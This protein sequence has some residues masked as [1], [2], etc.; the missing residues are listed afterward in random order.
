MARVLVIEDSPL[1]AWLLT[2]QLQSLG[3]MP[4]VEQRCEDALAHWQ[5]GDVDVVLVA[6]QLVRDNGFQCGT[7]LRDAGF[8]RILLLADVPR[9]TDVWWARGLGLGL[10]QSRGL[11]QSQSHG[12]CLAVLQRPL[13]LQ[14]LANALSANAQ[15]AAREQST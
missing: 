11:D 13:T 15:E 5:A 2:R 7:E 10:D 9:D 3:H 8:E 6:L 4:M 12:E 14:A 1:Q